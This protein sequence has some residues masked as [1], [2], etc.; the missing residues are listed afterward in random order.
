MEDLA[1]FHRGHGKLATL[2]AVQINLQYGVVEADESGLVTGFVERPRLSQWING[3]FFI[4]E[5]E[6]LDLIP[7]DED[8]NLEKDVLSHLADVGELMAY[9]HRGFW[10]SMNTMKD[11]LLLEEL[12]QRGAPWKVW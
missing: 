4:F 3:G 6:V 2:T 11:N 10:Q 5:K 7:L 8:V 9:R 12:W 1:E